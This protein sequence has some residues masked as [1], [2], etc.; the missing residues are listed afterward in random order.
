MLRKV[1]DM[2][3]SVAFGG[4]VRVPDK[5]DGEI[6]QYTQQEADA[7]AEGTL[8]YRT[9]GS[10]PRSV[11]VLP[12]LGVHPAF[13]WWAVQMSEGADGGRAVGDLRPTVVIAV[14]ACVENYS[15][16]TWTILS[17]WS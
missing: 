13:R 3:K 10:L 4:Q 6:Y 15:C 8:P 16:P 14:L 9:L 7:H 5:R 11:A 1:F 2:S 17:R 12:E